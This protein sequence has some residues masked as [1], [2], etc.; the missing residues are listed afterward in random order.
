MMIDNVNDGTVCG[1]AH[2]EA[3]HIVIACAL[4]LAIGEKGMKVS[5][6]SPDPT[7]EA[8][9]E[10]ATLGTEVVPSRVDNVVIALLAGGIAHRHFP[11]NVNA[12]VLIDQERI[13]ELLGA[14]CFTSP[15]LQARLALLKSQAEELVDRHWPMIEK[16]ATAICRKDWAYR[17]PSNSFFREKAM[18]GDD[19]RSMLYPMPFWWIPQLSEQTSF[20]I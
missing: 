9:F 16:V 18:S 15:G 13:A 5:V 20:C 7:G 8:H 14:D 12:A 17:Y 10:G 3:A 1:V 19:L 2:H 11:G 6:R 4:G